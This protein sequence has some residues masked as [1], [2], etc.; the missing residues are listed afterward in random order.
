MQ[1]IPPWMAD[2]CLSISC[3]LAWRI[4]S[5]STKTL[6]FTRSDAQCGPLM[7]PWQHLGDGEHTIQ[8]A[9]T[10]GDWNT[11]KGGCESVHSNGNNM[12]LTSF[13]S[14]LL[15]VSHLDLDNRDKFLMPS[16]PSHLFH[17][18]F[19]LPQ[20]TSYTLTLQTTSIWPL[21]DECVPLQFQIG[22]N[23]DTYGY[24]WI[25]NHG[26]RYSM[27]TDTTISG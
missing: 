21:R 4:A 1:S 6:Y 19:N 22:T 20:V 23:V 2:S 16:T 14:H 26:Y 5:S 18:H 24:I 3:C 17:L 8:D 15:G 27:D 13:F 7:I 11:S 12:Q 25:C 9:E 10:W